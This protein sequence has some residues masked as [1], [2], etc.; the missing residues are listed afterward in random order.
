M[1]LFAS[2]VTTSGILS[3][4]KRRQGRS[5]NALTP[6]EERAILN[7]VASLAGG[8]FSN[9]AY[10]LDTPGAAVRSWL[11]GKGFV[12]GATASAQDRTSGRDLLR[13]AGVADEEDTWSNYLAGIG[14]EIATDPLSILTGP[15]ASLTRAGK[16]AKAAGILDGSARAASR[17]FLQSRTGGA[18]LRQ[19][20]QDRAAKGFDK[21]TADGRTVTDSDLF[22]RPLVGKRAAQKYATLEDVVAHADD[23]K[24]A[25]DA[26]VTFLGKGDAAQ[27]KRLYDE[28]KGQNLAND[29]GI[30]GVG[31]VSLGGLGDT[32]RDLLDSVGRGVRW[33]APGRFVAS[34]FDKRVNQSM[35]AEAQAIGIAAA[36]KSTAR[37]EAATQRAVGELTALS[38]SKAAKDIFS[39]DGNRMLGRL[40][41]GNATKED[42]AFQSLHPAVQKYVGF[43]KSEGADILAESRQMGLRGQALKDPYGL[44]YLPYQ[45]DSMFEMAG[46]RDASLRDGL[47][48]MTG[49]MLRRG[50]TLRL[51]GGRDQ[52]MALSQDANVTGPKRLRNTDASAADYLAQKVF[53]LP[54]ASLK[55]KQK[56]Q[57]DS[58][59]RLLHKLPNEATDK[60]ALFGQHPTRQIQQYM[61]GRAVAAGNMDALLDGIVSYATGTQARQA[62]GGPMSGRGSI[63]INEAL[64]RINARSYKNK[65]TKV[66]IGGRQQIRERLA[67][68]TGK[69]V[70]SIDLSQYSIPLEHVEKITKATEVFADPGAASEL[71]KYIDT[72]TGVWKASILA[73][74]S[75]ITRDLYSGQ[76]SNWLVGA[77]SLDGPGAARVLLRHGADSQ[78]FAR[79]L[80]KLPQYSSLPTMERKAQAFYADLASTGLMGGGAQLDRTATI[81]GKSV[82]DQLPGR[83]PVTVGSALAELGPQAGRTWGEFGSDFFT[84]PTA[85]TPYADL[86]N[87][88]LRAGDQANQLSDGINRLSGY[89]ALLEKGFSPSAAAEQIKRVQVDYSNLSAFER[90]YLRRIFPWYTYQ[91]KI[92]QEVLSQL[93]TRPGGKYAQTIRAV[94][95]GQQEASEGSYVPSY[96]RRQVAIPVGETD[97]GTVYLSDI[98]LP[99]FDQIN[100]IPSTGDPLLG[101]MDQVGAQLSPHLRVGAELLSGRDFYY[102]TPIQESDRGI[103]ST[104]Y[105]NTVGGTM[106]YGYVAD[107]IIGNVPFVQRP[108]TFIRKVLDDR[109]G[110]PLPTRLGLAAVDSILGVKA[111]IV[112]QQRIDNDLNR[113][114]EES[115]EDVPQTRT[116]SRRYIP[117]ELEPT[118]PKWAVDRLRLSHRRKQ[119]GP[120]RS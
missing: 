57:M 36:A 84:M 113:I 110:A 38:Q 71:T 18:P 41:E 59:A 29:L 108:A 74:P 119:Q 45:A 44:N 120:Q 66:E 116:M 24:K 107:R 67:A 6:E 9:L 103:A 104:V 27:G 28:L 93:A 13:Q 78:Q 37:R 26:V 48:T 112:N 60:A 20:L 33:S 47:S 114:L 7:D 115:V 56:K 39:E 40:I 80:E 68:A 65:A 49:D 15:A 62:T 91:S 106:P 17:K 105:R 55:G 3:R 88:I 30:A 25:Q 81:S 22:A 76:F 82:L 19:E 96:L 75:R 98:D 16:A 52:I 4:G 14:V 118:A 31:S 11:A 73:F 46:S 102:K 83:T 117:E 2:P 100:M 94:D 111:P 109:S 63:S 50:E 90:N 101:A 8:T 10:A 87:P 58:L 35:D 92:M 61:E 97:G 42:L 1:S 64:K 89:Y 43:W 21:F 53:S 23:A 70:N 77:A 79:Y 54:Y 12:E 69:P 5:E 85:L 51:P 95:R 86:K 72:F 34:K 32:Y 99:G